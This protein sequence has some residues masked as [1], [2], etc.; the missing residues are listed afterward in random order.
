M[1]ENNMLHRNTLTIQIMLS[2]LVCELIV[3]IFEGRTSSLRDTFTT[4]HYKSPVN[5]ST[6][7]KLR[8]NQMRLEIK[9]TSLF[10]QI[11]LEQLAG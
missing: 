4:I 1:S 8:H 9:K 6:H 11:K 3:R 5:P 2:K 10:Q 7:K